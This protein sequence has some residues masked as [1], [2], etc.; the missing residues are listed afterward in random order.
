MILQILLLKVM[1]FNIYTYWCQIQGFSSQPAPL[2]IDISAVLSL[3]PS[4]KSIK[5]IILTKRPQT[6]QLLLHQKSLHN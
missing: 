1:R 3:D 4:L 5:P 6:C 2:L